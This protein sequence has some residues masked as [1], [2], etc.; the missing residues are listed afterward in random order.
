MLVG[1][2]EG[3]VVT[4]KRLCR[5]IELV[6]IVPHVAVSI[7]RAAGEVG[8]DRGLSVGESLAVALRGGCVD[9]MIAGSRGGVG[10]ERGERGAD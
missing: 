7:S 9:G 1:V 4:R 8:G 3:A 2:L 6:V 10:G 5:E